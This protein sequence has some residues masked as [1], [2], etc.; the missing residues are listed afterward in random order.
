MFIILTMLVQLYIQLVF[1]RSLYQ[2][3]Y[4]YIHLLILMTNEHLNVQQDV[5]IYYNINQS[6]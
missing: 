5:Y 4:C 2:S 6:I 3:E 1:S